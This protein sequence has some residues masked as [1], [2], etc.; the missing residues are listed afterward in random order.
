MIGTATHTRQ[1]NQPPASASRIN[2]HPEPV[3]VRD[4]EVELAARVDGWDRRADRI[5]YRVPEAWSQAVTPRSDPLVIAALFSAM[6]LRRDMHVYGPVSR[7]LLA[8]LEQFQDVWSQWKPS[9]YHRIEITADEELDDQHDPDKPA[10]TAFSGGLDSCFT[11]LRHKRRMCG[12][13]NRHVGAGLLIHGFDLAL[14]DH[15]AFTQATRHARAILDAEGVPMAVVRTNW[16]RDVEYNWTC[17]HGAALASCLHIFGGEFG[18]GMLGSSREY[19]ELKNYTRG[20]NALTD[21]MISSESFR[22]MHDGADT[23]RVEK[24]AIL[25]NSDAAS[26]H[27]RVCTAR[28]NAGR[29][30][31]K[32]EKCI[33]TLLSL[34]VA[35]IARPASFDD[36]ATDRD[37]AGIPIQASYQLHYLDEILHVADQRGITAEWVEVLRRRLSEHRRGGDRSFLR[38]LRHRLALRARWRWV[39]GRT[40]H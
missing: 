6:R 18:F 36:D 15:E 17:E 21:P 34:R 40:G 26:T 28:G 29:N 24:A 14:Q 2:V 35:G 1:V 20:S 27:V 4:G 33:R 23:A 32:C 25:G 12:R 30:C 10:I 7:S 22:V 9:T 13:L 37:I 38:S 5:W 19:R 31:G 8:N 11:L 16:R 3:T 39:V